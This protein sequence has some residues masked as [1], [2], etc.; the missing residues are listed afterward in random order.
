MSE[1][2]RFYKTI[3][4]ADDVPKRDRNAI[5]WRLKVGKPSFPVYL[6]TM[7][8]GS[9]QLDIMNSLFLNQP[10]YRNNPPEIVGIAKSQ[11][12]A[13]RLVRDLMQECVDRTGDALILPYLESL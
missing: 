1:M 6:I 12:G 13:F 11:E 7:P 9:N 4:W 10:Y 3:Y 2:V 8:E 5:R